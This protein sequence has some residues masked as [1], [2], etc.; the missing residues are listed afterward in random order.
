M[1]AT[2]LCQSL[3]AALVDEYCEVSQSLQQRGLV[4][5]VLLILRTNNLPYSC[6]HKLH[7][8]QATQQP[9]VAATQQ[10]AWHKN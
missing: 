6:C 2:L 7:S 1:N 8:D 4:N 3:H 10:G 9:S 5:P